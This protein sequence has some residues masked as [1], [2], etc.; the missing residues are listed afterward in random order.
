MTDQPPV[1]VTIGDLTFDRIRY[2][3]WVGDL[4]LDRGTKPPLIEFQF[5]P[6]F[7]HFVGIDEDGEVA[8]YTILYPDL[9]IARDGELRFHFPSGETVALTPEEAAPLLVDPNAERDARRRRR[10]ALIQRL[11]LGDR[12]RLPRRLRERRM[13]RVREA[14][15]A[16][17]AAAGS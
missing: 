16:R 4:V 7:D 12:I 17:R 11:T 2:S 5:E 10:E 9:F 3:E 8:Q 14:S 13:R 1:S 6:V 15:D